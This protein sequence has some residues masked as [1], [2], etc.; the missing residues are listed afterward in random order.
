M[1][2]RYASLR[3][4]TFLD[5]EQWRFT[6]FPQNPSNRNS[7][8]DGYKSVAPGSVL[9]KVGGYCTSLAIIGLITLF[10]RNELSVNTTTVGFTFLLAIL[11]ASTIWGFGVAAAMSVVATLA[12]DY[13]FLPPVGSLN[14][15]DPQD[16][17]GLSCFLL[18]SVLG[19]S[20]SA[21][22]HSRAVEANRRRREVEQLYALSQRL[23]GEG[24]FIELSHAIP[25]HIV[26]SFGADSAALFLSG[27]Q[28]VHRAGKELPQLDDRRLRLVAVGKD[29]PDDGESST[30]FA[31]LRLGA[32]VIGSVGISGPL[33]SKETMGA[34]GCLIAVT[35]ERAGAIEHVAR[36]EAARASEQ[37][38]SVMLDAIT[39]DF[40]TPLTC[41]K[42]SVTALLT[43]LEFDREQKKDLLVVVD[44]E[45]DR[46]DQLLD[47][48]SELARLESG[49]VKLDPAPHSIGELIS[50]ALADCKGV[51]RVRPIHCEVKHEE[52]RVFADLCWARSV[53]V[54]LIANAHLYSRPRH[55]IT[56]STEKR[57]GFALFSVADEG[58]G[59]EETE[60]ARIF[61][62]FYR[63][64]NQEHRAQG[65]GMGLPIARAIVEA[66]GGTIDVVS[67][68]GHGSVFTFSL[69][70]DLRTT[71]SPGVSRLD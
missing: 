8:L 53:L 68:C 6:P 11:S 64:K 65:T 63:C 54:Q 14:I 37:F 2:S 35:I 12:F 58:P 19:S 30:W 55:P 33:V 27:K 57:G 28:E 43:D 60:A 56:V 48:A 13:F 71:A 36:M 29:M 70:L 39:H 15:A 41:I 10:Y 40:R 4:L 3:S 59:I 46:I 21:R 45:C 23:L 49:E 47:R 61:E 52:L 24:N 42:S 7:S 20:L 62:K 31:A 9:G 22:A 18:T 16:W 26:D 50:T 69:P 25:Q 38:K 67:R 44:E 51:S 5:Q 1:T 32:N 17:V 66:H 34:L